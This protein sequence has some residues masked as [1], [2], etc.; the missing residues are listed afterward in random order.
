M[1]SITK[2][3]ILILIISVFVVGSGCDGA[4]EN[5]SFILSGTVT[6]SSSVLE[7]VSVS[8]SRD[9]S[10]MATVMTGPQ[11]RYEARGLDSGCY[12]VVPG[13]EGYL[14][15]PA[16]LS[17]EIDGA[18][19]EGA[20]FTAATV[21]SPDPGTDPE[22]GEIV[23]L[24]FVGDINLGSG[25]GQAVDAQA[26]GDY[27]FPFAPVAS[28]LSGFDLTIGNL[29]S[30]IS[31]QGVTT[32]PV[33]GV[34]L[35]AHPNAIQGLLGAGFDIVSVANN[36]AGD[37]GEEGMIDSFNRLAAAGIGCAGG[38]INRTGARAPVIRQV[39]GG[40]IACLAY[41]NVPMYMDSFWAGQ[42]PTSRW[43]ATD[44]RAG[45]A[46]AHDSR[47]STFGNLDDMRAD[48]AAAA[49]QADLVVVMVHF[50]WEYNYEP[51]QAQID[52]A[53]AAIDAGAKLVLGHH[54]HVTQPVE[55]YHGGFIAYSLG[56]FIFDISEA[57]A[58]GATRGMVVEARVQNGDI[59]DVVTRYSRYNEFFQVSLE[60]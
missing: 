15:T 32:K 3:L 43:L 29:E 47:F 41:T 54:P 4:D 58:A 55:E 48:I 1:V 40:T 17:V 11:G 39:R 30:I 19:R 16:S 13:R 37:F 10:V 2:H 52:L 59:V 44:D 57:R 26:G 36:H 24:V 9:G 7:G 34:S 50:G 49:V 35:R 51:D 18:D 12:L 8:I 60:E 20:D 23:S 53:R 28:Y 5:M 33:T 38:G 46:W 42:M 31:D 6:C 21:G 22:D 14:F 27:N 56:N 45:V 25:V